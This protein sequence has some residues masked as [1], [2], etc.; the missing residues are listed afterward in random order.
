MEQVLGARR[1]LLTRG[2]VLNSL[3]SILSLLILVRRGLPYESAGLGTSLAPALLISYVV[4]QPFT[5]N[6]IRYVAM[7]YNTVRYRK[8]VAHDQ[9]YFALLQWHL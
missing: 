2:S 1:V 4:S 6:L 8:H 5:E 7:R 9:G 3:E